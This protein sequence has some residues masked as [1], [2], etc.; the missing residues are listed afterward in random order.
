MQNAVFIFTKPGLM[1]IIKKKM[2]ARF[3]LVI[4]QREKQVNAVI[5][6]EIYQSMD[7]WQSL[8][9]QFCC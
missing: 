3:Q 8:M 4:S 2:R 1:A 7:V 6:F 5:D 9:T